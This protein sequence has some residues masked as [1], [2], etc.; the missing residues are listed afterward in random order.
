MYKQAVGCILT[1]AV[2]GDGAA[3]I[4]GVKWSASGQRQQ[5]FGPDASSRAGNAVAVL[6]APRAHHR[7]ARS[8]PDALVKAS[9][10]TRAGRRRVTPRRRLQFNTHGYARLMF[11]REE[12]SLAFKTRLKET[13]DVLNY[14]FMCNAVTLIYNIT[15]LEFRSDRGGASTQAGGRKEKIK[16]SWVKKEK[17]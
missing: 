3:G 14:L 5:A 16:I 1:G 8:V 15:L 9:C 13:S 17:Q 6:A 7:R 10:N 4:R 2:V 12:T 11:P